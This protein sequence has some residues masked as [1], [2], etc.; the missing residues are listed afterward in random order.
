MEFIAQTAFPNLNISSIAWGIYEAIRLE[1]IAKGLYP[2]VAGKTSAQVDAEVELIRQSGIIPIKVVPMVPVKEQGDTDN[3]TI[4]ITLAAIE[5]GTIGGKSR[6]YEDT[7]SNFNR[8][9]YPDATRNIIFLITLQAENVIALDSMIEV[10][11]DALGYQEITQI[12]SY[13]F[14]N[15]QTTDIDFEIE[16]MDD[17]VLTI[18]DQHEVKMTYKVRDVYLQKIKEKDIAKITSVRGFIDEESTDPD[19]VSP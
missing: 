5:K 4:F 10:M 11:S 14:A 3:G 7:G 13:D 12:S 1:L 2:D 16:H 9:S 17:I 8:R 15:S 18:A 19:I 6:D